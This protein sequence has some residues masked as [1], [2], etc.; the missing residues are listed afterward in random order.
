LLG[1]AIPLYKFALSLEHL[2]YMDDLRVS[3]V[4]TQPIIFSDLNVR[5]IAYTLI[6]SYLIVIYL[7]SHTYEEL[8]G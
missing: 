2:G 8:Q 3:A 6:S 5:R 7:T 1:A 4:S